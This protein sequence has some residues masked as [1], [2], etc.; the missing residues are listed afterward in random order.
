MNQ[1]TATMP[2]TLR[3]RI[4]GYWSRFLAFTPDALNRPGITMTTAPVSSGLFLLTLGAG[5]ICALSPDTAPALAPQIRALSAPDELF[6]DETVSQLLASV[7]QIDMLYG[8]GEVL[9]CTEDG[10]RDGET[11]RRRRLTPDDADALHEFRRV[12]G[13]YSDHHRTERF[14]DWACA[15]GIFDGEELAS[16]ARV[17]A[18]DG[19]IGAVSAAT[20]P[21]CR[22]LG[23]GLSVVRGC[24]RWMLE[25]TELIPQVDGEL[26]KAGVH[27]ARA[28]GYT[29]YGYI[30]VGTL[31]S[32]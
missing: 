13:W 17:W 5:V 27:M 21:D 20:R 12:M 14:E 23:Y 15:M 9:Y 26:E 25:N 3:Q 2:T 7:G 6:S 19:T 28:S 29:H 31:A 30:L 10:F 22:N 24:T 4:D 8:P 32:D 11:Y 18:W 16:L 1:M